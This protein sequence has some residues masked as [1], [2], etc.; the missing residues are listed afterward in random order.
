[1]QGHE[2]WMAWSDDESVCER[3]D[4]C[5]HVVIVWFALGFEGG[6]VGDVA[7]GGLEKSFGLG[8]QVVAEGDLAGKEKQMQASHWVYD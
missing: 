1:M 5:L 6:E 4:E 3:R 8:D 2:L 7:D